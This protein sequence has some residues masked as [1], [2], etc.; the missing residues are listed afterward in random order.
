MASLQASSSPEDMKS[1]A[2][3]ALYLHHEFSTEQC[4]WLSGVSAIT[5][6]RS[7]TWDKRLTRCLFKQTLARL[8]ALGVPLTKSSWGHIP[9]PTLSITSVAPASGY[10][11]TS[12]FVCVLLSLGSTPGLL[13]VHLSPSFLSLTLFRP[14]LSWPRLVLS[15]LLWLCSLSCV[16]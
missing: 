11:I 15:V 5:G 10:Y 2:L 13:F 4:V 6:G 8:S 1:K 12:H 16:Q 9:P 7:E 14:L 3:L